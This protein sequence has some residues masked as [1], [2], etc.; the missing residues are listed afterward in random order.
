MTVATCVAIPGLSH[1][2]SDDTLQYMCSAATLVLWFHSRTS[3]RRRLTQIVYFNRHCIRRGSSRRATYC[4][5]AVVPYLGHGKFPC[6]SGVVYAFLPNIQ[7]GSQ[8]IH[9]TISYSVYED[10]TCFVLVH[11]ALSV[12]DEPG[13]LH[14]G[15]LV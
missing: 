11:S 7:G 9:A 3:N 14:N 12:F 2:L 13:F 6:S 8:F 10:I 15:I 4:S 1:A 5:A